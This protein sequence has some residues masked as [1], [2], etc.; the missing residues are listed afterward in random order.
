MI[1][2]Y[3]L[4]L[5]HTHTHTLSLSLSLL[6]ARARSLSLSLSLFLTPPLKGK[7]NKSFFYKNHKTFQ[8]GGRLESS[9]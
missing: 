6:R 2:H 8:G 9:R 4:S 3:S 1:E 5:S 7:I